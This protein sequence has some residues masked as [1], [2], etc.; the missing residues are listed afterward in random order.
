MGHLI[1]AKPSQRLRSFVSERCGGNALYTRELVRHLEER[2]LMRRDGLGATL[3][4]EAEAGIPDGMQTLIAARLDVLDPA[5]KA[6]LVDAAVVGRTF[7]LGAVAAVGETREDD[8]R[9]ALDE[10]V[11][12]ELVRTQRDSTLAREQ[13]FA[14]WHTLTHEVAYGQ[15]TR[16]ARCAKH[17]RV[18]HWIEEVSGDQPGA[19]AETLAYHYLTALSLA[20]AIRNAV[21][22]D[23]AAPPD[24]QRAAARGSARDGARRAA[25]RAALREGARRRGG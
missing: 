8:A 7:W 22:V 12:R 20:Q 16:A 23:R 24:S 2:S 21:L 9:E 1:D 6:V 11:A 4:P 17:T 15:L 14:F 19:I 5:H 18:A 25:R 3:L 13:Q 10:L